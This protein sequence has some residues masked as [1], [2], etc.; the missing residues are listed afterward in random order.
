MRGDLLRAEKKDREA[1]ADGYLRVII[2]HRQQ[3]E[4][5]SEALYKA[6]ET[7]EALGQTPYAEKMRTELLARYSDSEEAKKLRGK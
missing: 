3:R 2:F 4:A 1:L 7:F 5:M 6:M